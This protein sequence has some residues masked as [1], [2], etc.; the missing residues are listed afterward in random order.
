MLR[1]IENFLNDILYL[2]DDGAIISAIS[3]HSLEDRIVKTPYDDILAFKY[4]AVVPTSG[5]SYAYSTSAASHD[6][7]I[8]AKE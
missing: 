6:L 5:K 4:F 2:L 7:V 1:N 3:F 8:T